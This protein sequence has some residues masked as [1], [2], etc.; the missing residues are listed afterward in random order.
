MTSSNDN[1][2]VEPEILPSIVQSLT[3]DEL[4]CYKLAKGCI[5]ELALFLKPNGNSVAGLFSRPMQRKLVTL[6]NCQLIE[7]EGRAR[8]LRAARS[9]GERTVTELILQHQNPQQLS[10]NLWAAVRARG[11]QFLGPAM[12]EEVLKLVLLALEDGVSLCRKVLVMFVVQRL[13]AAF[14]Q[15]SKT[16]IG[17]VVQLLY[18]ASCFIVS[19]RDG[20]SSLMQLKEEFRTYKS[21]RKEHDAQIVQIAT[22]AGLRIAPDQWSALLYGDPDHKSD[23]QSLIDKQQSPQSFGQS[24]QELMI[25]LQRTNDPANL[26]ALRGHLNYLSLIDASPDSSA[27][28]TWKECG[29]A[30]EAVKHVVNGLVEFM[31]SHGSRKTQESGHLSHTA[32]FKISFCRD[33]SIRGN[34][35]RGSNCTFAH[36]D[37]ELE[38]YRA[39]IKK[40]TMRQPIK[41]PVNFS[42]PNPKVNISQAYAGK[43]EAIPP[44]FNKS[45]PYR[46]ENSLNQTPAKTAQHLMPTYP[47]NNSSSSTPNLSQT[48]LSPKIMSA[49]PSSQM[50]NRFSYNDSYGNYPTNYNTSPPMNQAPKT[51]YHQNYRP[52]P[53][54]APPVSSYMKSST[55]GYSPEYK[56]QYSPY[57]GPMN[58]QSPMMKPSGYFQMPPTMSLN[59]DY[60]NNNAGADGNKYSMNWRSGNGNS[61]KAKSVSK[62]PNHLMPMSK[63][64][65]L[66][67]SCHTSPI[68]RSELSQMEMNRMMQRNHSN[69]EVD[70]SGL[71][72]MWMAGKPQPV[73]QF[74][75]Q[76][77]ENFIRS[78]SILTSNTDDEFAFDIMNISGNKYGPI[79]IRNQS[80][81]NNSRQWSGL[82]SA[83]PK[84]YENSIFNSGSNGG[85][86]N[87]FT[88]TRMNLN[89]NGN[90]NRQF[91][92][93]FLNIPYGNSDNGVSS[94]GLIEDFLLV[95][96]IKLFFVLHRLQA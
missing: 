8:S 3:A 5:E 11:C 63:S 53:L 67:N 90:G 74:T 40:H 48:Q 25:A 45:M 88:N 12:Q 38:R 51:A 42:G 23:M 29:E 70:G 92:T 76:A 91:K 96:V 17:H 81:D 49:P 24:V 86:G 56:K 55:S 66:P 4:Q 60:S 22:E 1:N 36:N 54:S 21:L 39:K 94:K 28:P 14:P 41:G 37:E 50:N 31:Q 77:K 13:E 75:P 83:L 16:S 61:D 80:V 71:E 27:V 9:L 35:P 79:G 10:A 62:S 57:H 69:D 18:R 19:K 93:N 89:S 52:P 34:C 47:S 84:R 68:N 65:L 87:S 2:N 78:D 26:S 85:D 72:K 73:F 59:E 15:A 43:S 82:H 64:P 95:F 46:S 30:V 20:D 7:E 6:L 33:L 58:S 32:R 44:R